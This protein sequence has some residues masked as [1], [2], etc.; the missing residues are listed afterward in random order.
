MIEY[1]SRNGRDL[2]Q[3]TNEHLALVFIAMLLACAIGIPLGVVASRVP[4]LQRPII[5]LANV[6]QTVP[7]LALFGFLLP[8]LGSGRAQRH[9]GACGVF[10]ATLIR[11]TVTGITGIDRSV[12]EA[13]VA[14]G[15]TDRQILWQVELPLASSVILA[16]VRVATVLC[17]GIATI[18]SFIGAGGLGENIQNGLRRLDNVETLAGAIPAALLALAADATLG[19]L[20]TRLE[21]KNHTHTQTSAARPRVFGALL[22]RRSRCCCCWALPAQCKEPAHYLEA[23]MPCAVTARPL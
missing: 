2:L 4:A 23:A 15:M 14:M 13:A 5:G 6:M 10:A 1:L 21:Q 11:N 7:S 3:H 18:A 22:T 17:I 9:R 16:G 8:L 20:Q 19:A 12:R